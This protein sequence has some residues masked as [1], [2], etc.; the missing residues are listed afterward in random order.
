[1]ILRHLHKPAKR[2]SNQVKFID[3]YAEAKRDAQAHDRESV[4]S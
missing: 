2:H 1:L 4:N 3:R